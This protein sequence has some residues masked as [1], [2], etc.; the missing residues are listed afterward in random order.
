MSSWACRTPAAT[1]RGEPVWL[2]VN[3]VSRID[4]AGSLR[5]AVCSFADI[6]AR[7][8]AE[9][10]ARESAA[11]FRAVYEN[12]GLGVLMRDID[13]AILSSNPT[14]SRMLGYSA[15]TLRSMP[16]DAMLHPGDR[17]LGGDEHEALLAGERETYE[18]DRRYVRRDGEIVWGH[19]TVSVVRG[20]SDEPQYVVE[21]IVDITDRKRMEAQLML[22]DRLAS[23]GTMAAGVAHE[24]NNP[25]TWLMGNVS[26]V[27]ESLEEL[28]DEIALDDDSADDLDKALADSLVG[29]ERIRT[30]V[31][32]LKLFARDREDEDGIADLGEVLHSTLRM[33]RN[34]LH[35]RAVLEQKVG[36]VPPVVGDP[37]R[38]G[39]VFTNLL[40]N[41]IH[42]LPD[43][44][45]EENR[46]EIRGV[47][48]GRGVVIEISDNGVGMSPETQARIFDPFYTTKEVGQ[49]TGLGL[50]ICHSIIAQI[51]GRI[52]VDSELGQGTTFRV[53]LARARRG[54]TSGIALTLI[55]EMPTE[56]KSLLCIDDEPD[57]GLTLK[58]MLGKYHDI[59]FET[60]GERALE[61]LREGERFDAII[62]DLMMPGMS[63]PEFY[64][65][66][67]EVAPELVSHCGFVTGGTFTPA[68]RAFAEEQRGYQLLQKPF[69]REAMYMFIAHLTAR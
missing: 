7:K 8:R 16:L 12:A 28:R 36:D 61:R 68:T 44:D 59:T 4:A 58:R 42:A 2:L 37:A 49:G 17:E 1:G 10:T 62:C 30:I 64:H 23:L 41:A 6:S 25:L 47:R 51:G 15:K 34:E 45:R 43:R 35:H 60:D 33:L 66:L 32:D 9:D 21:M 56:R 46:I 57:M 20:A 11:M 38:L 48:S 26:Y 65:S 63:G 27:R 67:G 22:T 31:Q 14:F 54:S 19:V 53:H 29:A 39:Q 69:S 40:V 24:I 18:V 52:E 5:W 13:G 55:D 50:S 3:V